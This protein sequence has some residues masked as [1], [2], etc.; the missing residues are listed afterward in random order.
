MELYR[1]VEQT[2]L[3]D[4]PWV[5]LWFSGERLVLVKPYVK[6]YHLTPMIIPKLRHVSI[7]R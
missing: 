2:I 4:A 1:Q 5:P 7:E 6:G 3:D